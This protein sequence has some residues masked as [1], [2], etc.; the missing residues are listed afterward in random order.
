M[1]RDRAVMDGSVCGG[2]RNSVVVGGATG[3]A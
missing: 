2:L 1:V 3:L